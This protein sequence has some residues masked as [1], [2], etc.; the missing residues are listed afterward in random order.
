MFSLRHNMGSLIYIRSLAPPWT[1]LAEIF[2]VPKASILPRLIVF[3]IST[4]VAYEIL[5]GSQIYIRGRAPRGR[6]L[7]EKF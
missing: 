2:F 6:P 1:P 7:A 4:L 3:L 5:G